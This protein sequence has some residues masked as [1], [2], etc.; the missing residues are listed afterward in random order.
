MPDA[1]A[2]SDWPAGILADFVA[3]QFNG[4]VGHV[5]LSETD[6]VRVWSLSLKPGERIHFHRHVLDYFWTVLTDGKSRSH[7]HDGR[8]Q[9]VI[10]RAGDTRHM[11]FGKGEF[12]VHDLENIG[13]GVLAYTT[14]EFL[15]SAN[16][17]LPVPDQVRH[18][19]MAAE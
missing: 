9:E 13:D 2:K 8:T 1:T 3:N 10:Y 4:C 11:A 14:V 19:F 18:G 6:R 17:A 16:E 12:M 7:Y 15:D 5:L